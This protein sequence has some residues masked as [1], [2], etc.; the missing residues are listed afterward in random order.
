[1]LT[2]EALE[3]TE[4]V[5]LA[6]E[7][8]HYFAETKQSGGKAEKDART[9]ERTI[10]NL[11]SLN[12]KNRLLGFSATFNLNNE[13]LFQKIR[14]KIVYQYDLKQFMEHKYSKNVMLLRADEDDETKMLHGVLLSQY[15][16]YVAQDHNIELK[17]VIL[18]KSNKIATSLEAN[19]KL[20]NMI[21][22]LTLAQ[23][24]QVIETGYAIYHKEQS[25]WTKMFDYYKDQ[26]LSKVI[27]DLQWDFSSG[28]MLNA[29]SQDFLTEENALLLNSL[30]EPNNPIRAIFAVARLNEGWDVLNLFDIVRI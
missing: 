20:I 19:Q 21:E 16:K 14:D 13:V 15:R 3:D 10:A 1:S 2:F 12:P 17:P 7:A 8:H 18:F 22:G 29:N 11:L 28:N 9:W 26:D 23:I 27:R 30:E 5:L 6:D 4:L 24:Q 25:I